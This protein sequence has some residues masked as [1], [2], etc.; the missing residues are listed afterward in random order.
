MAHHHLLLSA[1]LVALPPV[2]SPD[3]AGAAP[4]PPPIAPRMVDAFED[5]AVDDGSANG[6]ANGSA[7][8]P[9]P[10]ITVT[11]TVEPS[12]VV[13]GEA[14]ALVV[15][16]GRAAGVRVEL[17]AA[18]PEV[19]GAP[20]TGDPV[21]AVTDDVGGS[22][23]ADAGP[24]SRVRE[25]IRI[26]FLALDTSELKTPA[27]SLRAPD[28][29]ALEVPALT[30][31]VTMRDVNVGDA[32]P[33][34]L[35][36]TGLAPAA[37]SLS[38][39]IPDHRPLVGLGMLTG[40]VL[41]ALAARRLLRLRRARA[42][43]APPPPPPPRPAHVVALERLDALMA[44]GL[45]AR[46]ESA[47]FVERLM[48]DVLRDYVTA[49]FTLSAGTRTTRELVKDLLAVAEPG[50]DVA[51]VEALLADADLVKFAR[52]SLHPTDAHAMAGRVRS[53]IERTALIT[54]TSGH[55]AGQPA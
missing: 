9:A 55:A 15:T 45:L 4:L 46:G 49:R 53:F 26:P 12:P 3:D 29:S 13:F 6:S 14:F 36:G 37:A 31:T 52:A 42:A 33:T 39:A 34:A 5:A 22:A 44:S 2:T 41:A 25:T 27:F 35:D 51:Q 8:K 48:N 1:L 32:G 7:D 23:G 30:I 18:I 54:G 43:A 16:I 38:Y 40:A 17:P 24:A 28:G 20:R 21:R 11:A 50:L 19:E 47:P 10:D